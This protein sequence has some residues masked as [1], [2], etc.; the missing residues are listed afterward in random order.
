MYFTTP[1]STIHIYFK[2]RLTYMHSKKLL[3]NGYKNLQITEYIMFSLPYTYLYDYSY[4]IMYTFGHH[5]TYLLVSH[6]Y[7]SIYKF[8]L[9]KYIRET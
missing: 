3:F 1:D 9:K 4:N 5:T 8:E 6:I 2:L 7:E